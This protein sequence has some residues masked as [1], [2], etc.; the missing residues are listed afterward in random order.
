LLRSSSPPGPSISLS[1]VP[2]KLAS[3]RP[4]PECSS[5]PV[6]VLASPSVG[7]SGILPE[8][9]LLL[10]QYGSKARR[11][12][13]GVGVFSSNETCCASSGSTSPAPSTSLL[14]VL[15]P[16]DMQVSDTKNPPLLF[17]CM[18][19]RSWDWVEANFAIDSAV[20]GWSVPEDFSTSSAVHP[21][22]LPCRS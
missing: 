19:R 9:G 18:I 7:P 12:F 3:G 8:S 17:D 14:D 2:A 13:R 16:A 1:N 22:L 20:S 5:A 15:L 6:V 10:L 4:I 21:F 11:Y